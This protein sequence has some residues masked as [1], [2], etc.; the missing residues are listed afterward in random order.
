M[1]GRETA[2]RKN[3]ARRGG[4]REWWRGRKDIEQELITTRREVDYKMQRG[5]A[6]GTRCGEENVCT[7][8]YATF[9]RRPVLGA[10]YTPSILGG[11]A[12]A[13]SCHL[14]RRA[15][16]L[17]SNTRSPRCYFLLFFCASLFFFPF[18]PLFLVCLLLCCDC[19]EAKR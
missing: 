5:A 4:R 6:G 17:P 13:P 2:S 19:G 15:G 16:N 14:A 9:S 7:P 3:A 1:R 11:G 12:R 8:M 10:P 18:S